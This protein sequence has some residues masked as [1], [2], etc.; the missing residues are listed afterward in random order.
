MNP[1][2]L[3]LQ[4]VGR[5]ETFDLELHDGC[6]ALL[7]GNGAGKSTVLNAIEAALF[8]NGGRDLG[9]MLAPFGDRL[10]ITLWFE[11]RGRDYRV[12]RGMKRGGSA[13]LDLEQYV[14]HPD[15][16]GAQEDGGWIPLTRE[17]TAA[18]QAELER[19]LGL[20][21]RAFRSSSFLAQREA[22][23]FLKATA[24]D[25]KQILGEMLDGPG[26]WPR[27]AKLAGQDAAR[28]EAEIAGDLQRIQE[29]EE[30]AAREPE[31]LTLHGQALIL[32][33]AASDGLDDAESVL[34]AA[35]AA[36]QANAAAAERHKAAVAAHRTAEMERA[37][38]MTELQAAQGFAD[39]LEPARKQLAELEERAARIPYLEKWVDEQKVARSD[40][41]LAA[42]QRQAG[43]NAAASL[44]LEAQRIRREGVLLGEEQTRRTDQLAALRH[45][46]D[47]HATCDRCRQ[48]LGVEARAAAI[49][50]LTAEIDAAEKTIAAKAV[51]SRLA[52]QRH[53][54]AIAEFEAIIVPGLPTVTVDHTVELAAAR[55]A[56]EQRGTVATLIAGYEEHALALDAL[57]ANLAGAA[58]TLL[59]RTDELEQASA[60]MGDTAQLDQTV[61]E[62][63][64]TVTAR[65][66]A[67]DEAKAAVVRVEEQLARVRQAATELEALRA[68]INEKQSELELYRISERSRSRDG[69]PTL[70][71]ENALGQIEADT[72]W[73]LEH[74]PTQDGAVFRATYI[75]QREQKSVEHLKETLEVVI[76]AP[77]YEQRS[78]SL[79]GGE[80]TRVALAIGFALAA[81][82]GAS[83]FLAA[84]ELPYLDDL[85]EEAVVELLKAAVA[86]GMFTKILVVSHS[87]NVRDAFDQVIE[88]EK[89]DGVSRVAG[90]RVEVPA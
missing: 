81:R 54:D 36:M 42:A 64:T 22:N 21:R 28:V 73:A 79:S 63:R 90:A 27:L 86:R 2:R 39:K 35:Q 6:T 40:R 49:A 1:R 58:A 23:A 68:R 18:T 60:G 41:D 4:N 67:L 47:G 37:R 65:R 77:D 85:G 7:G 19:L 31:I 29:R 83:S 76:T 34:E 62:A 16:V 9:A 80:E 50:S 59:Q 51:E 3:T 12:R 57:T 8:A 78:E 89:Q 11:H 10:E 44:D 15:A 72:N 88:I 25:K 75:T 24:G 87:P 82:I 38:A 43:M 5:F 56:A 46:E 32:N 69:I 14:L 74:L 71:A 48:T 55:Q 53:R 26:L 20:T 66:S 33:D 52:D 13:T 61:T 30:I 70:I 17:S 84:D 45:A